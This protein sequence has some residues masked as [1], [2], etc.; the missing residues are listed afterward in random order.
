MTFK[1]PC[2]LFDGPLALWPVE[3]VELKAL[4]WLS[5]DF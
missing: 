3:K 4:M 2:V 5:D 1:H